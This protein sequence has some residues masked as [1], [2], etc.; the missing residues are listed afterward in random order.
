MNRHKNLPELAKVMFKLGCIA[1]GGPAA[2]LAMMEKEVVEKRKWM[3]REHFLDLMGATNL[4]P[5]PNS[6]QMTM[7]CGMERAGILGLF[8]GGLAFIL[9]AVIIT[10]IFAYLYVKFSQVPQVEPF[11]YGIQPAVIAII[12]SAVMKLAPK[13]FKNRELWILGAAAMTASLLGVNEIVCLLSSGII[14]AIYF[15]IKENKITALN[16][17]APLV[18][19]PLASEENRLS[20]MSIFG[21]FIKIAMVLYGSG[22]LLFAYLDAE[23]VA[24]GWMTKQELMDAIAVGQFTPGPVLSSATFVGYQLGSVQGAIFATLGMFLPSFLLILVLNPI[25]PK[26][27]KSKPFALFL[28]SVNAAAVALIAA[29][30]IDMGL[31]TLTDW[32]TIALAAMGIGLSL[33]L[34]NINSMWLVLAGS[35]GGYVLSFL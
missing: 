14:G 4:I 8:I 26:M 1:F 3:T 25:I 13:A 9:P 20:M 33:T 5:G 21:M 35:L 34:K 28:N 22:Y 12:F 10:G 11:I 17:I 7:H 16:S 24:S 2:H 18:L 32:K 15:W 29:V 30:L 23:F 19:M 31:E 27:R 6:T